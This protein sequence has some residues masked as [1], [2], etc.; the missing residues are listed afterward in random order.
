MR[1]RRLQ[2]GLVCVSLLAAMGSLGVLAQQQR[3]QVFVSVVDSRGV[4][5]LNL[6]PDAFKIFENQVASKTLTVEPIDWPMKITVLVDNGIGMAPYIANLR[7][8]L[9]SF[10]NEI[11]DEVELSLLTLA[12]QPR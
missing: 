8:G 5:V 1:R 10:F 9:R 6:G 3:R 4:P 12:P 11:P 2:V 7:S